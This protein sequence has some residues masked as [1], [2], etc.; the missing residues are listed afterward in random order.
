MRC[1]H[2]VSV[3]PLTTSPNSAQVHLQ[4]FTSLPI[5]TKEIDAFNIQSWHATLERLLFTKKIISPEMF[6]SGC[7]YQTLD[8]IQENKTRQDLSAAILNCTCILPFYGR[9]QPTFL[10]SSCTTKLDFLPP[11]VTDIL[12][13]NRKCQ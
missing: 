1:T 13:G 10:L 5:E 7:L 6:W 2:H 9:C 4:I 12:N 11:S 3:P 8:L